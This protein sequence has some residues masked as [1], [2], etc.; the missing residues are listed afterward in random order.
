MHVI[1]GRFR[2]RRL[3]V[4]AGRGTRPTLSRIRENLFNILNPRMTGSRFLDLFAGSGSIGCEALSRGARRVTMVEFNA[5]AHAALAANV[6]RLDPHG[7]ATRLLKADATWGL[8]QLVHAGEMFDIAFL[9]PPYGDP[10]P[11]AAW[12]RDLAE[13]CAPDAWIVVQH[14]RR[15][16]APD[17]WAG[18]RAFDRRGYGKTGL[19]FYRATPDTTT[20]S[21]D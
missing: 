21:T 10:W 9:D 2:G 14:A 4:P 15:A 1:A 13:L 19:T 11:E 6:A 17:A 16:I 20:G 3:D 7:E 18:R 5:R 12:Q 8:R